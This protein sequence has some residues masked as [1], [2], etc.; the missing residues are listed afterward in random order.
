L[1]DSLFDAPIYR[2][3]GGI[4]AEERF[5]P[6]GFAAPLGLNDIGLVD[7]SAQAFRVPMPL[8]SLL[9]DHLLQ[10]IAQE[11]EDLDWSARRD[12]P[13]AISSSPMTRVGL[14]ASANA[15]TLP[16]FSAAIRLITSI[17]RCS[18]GLK[19]TILDIIDQARRI[20]R[21]D[22]AFLGLF[23]WR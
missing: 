6:A 2:T 23:R 12:A 9:R 22:A 3:Y 4:L 7:Q 13:H 14:S 5:R 18:L 21:G 10:T 20:T 8:L 17:R 19:S 15:D 16:Q 11:G 1:T